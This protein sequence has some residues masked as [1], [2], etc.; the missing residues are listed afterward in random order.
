MAVLGEKE[1]PVIWKRNI[2][3]ALIDLADND[4]QYETWL[5]KNQNYISSYTETI[6]TLFDNYDFERY[7]LYYKS[8][9]GENSLSFLFNELIMMVDNYNEPEKDEDVLK[10]LKWI[11]ITDK[12]K[13]IISN[14]YK[15]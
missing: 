4:F 5:G 2:I 12:A 7:A 14:W 6:N 8:I 13:E 1:N 9:K 10:D 15:F 3:K 11:S